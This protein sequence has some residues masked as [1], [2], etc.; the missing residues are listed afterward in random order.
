MSLVFD[1]SWAETRSLCSCYSLI[2]EI[3]IYQLIIIQVKFI[4]GIKQKYWSSQPFKYLSSPCIERIGSYWLP[5]AGMCGEARVFAELE[6]D[7]LSSKQHWSPSMAHLFP[8][9]TWSKASWRSIRVA[10][11]VQCPSTGG[12]FER[13]STLAVPPASTTLYRLFR[14]P[15]L[16][17][18]VHKRTVLLWNQHHWYVMNFIIHDV[19]EF[20]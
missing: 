5:N 20:W 3:D 9:T 19:S 1:V 11:G 12:M 18:E 13:A 2:L 15:T 6:A 8:P 10:F 4:F 17:F 7:W 14:A 16:V